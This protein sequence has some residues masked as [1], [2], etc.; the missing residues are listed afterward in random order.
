MDTLI[1]GEQSWRQ[2]WGFP[3]NEESWKDIGQK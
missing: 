2:G 1:K 3:I